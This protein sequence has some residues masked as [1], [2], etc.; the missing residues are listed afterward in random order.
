MLILTG[1][2]VRGLLAG[3]E[4]DIVRA[5][6]DA[7]LAHSDGDTTL[8]HSSFLRLPESRNRIIALPAHQAKPTP[9]AGLKWIAS[10]PGNVER[11]M[12]RASAVMILN[13]TETGHP[14]AVVE[15]SLISAQRTAASAALAAQV[16]GSPGEG[17]RAGLV[18]CGVINFEVARFLRAT[19]PDISAL[20]VHDTDPR[21]A[22]GFA[23]RAAAAFPELD[24]TTSESVEAVIAESSVLSIATSALTP[25][26]QDLSGAPARAVV[27]HVSL[28]DLTPEA[29]LAADNYT[30]DIDHA[31]REQTSLHLAEQ[32]VGNRDF[33][34]ATLADVLRGTV[35]VPDDERP[36]V[37]SPFGLGILDLA[38]ATLVLD[39]AGQQG[40]GVDIPDFLPARHG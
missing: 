34:R 15:G 40:V 2:Q 19:R 37:F 29:V 9:A 28:R 1:E 3:H 26:I 16:L 11:D 27:L 4:N 23:E 38:L 24:V 12:D 18:G 13:S 8:P 35:T 20:T 36:R 21:R 31:V 22:K 14:T 7:Y 33:V 6:R 25:H 10:F 5:V 32:Q 39:L 30:D 17:T